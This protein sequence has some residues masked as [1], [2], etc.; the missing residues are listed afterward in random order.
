M[1]LGR[2][3]YWRQGRAKT[4]EEIWDAGPYYEQVSALLESAQEYVILAGWQIDS[5]LKLSSSPF[6]ESLKEKIRR[7]CQSKPRLHFYLLMWDHAYFL[8][9]ERELWQGRIWEGVHPNVHFVFDNRHPFGASHH[10]KVCITDGQTALCGGIDL[11]DERWDSPE[12][13]YLDPRRSLDGLSEHHG[14]YHDMAVRVTG[15]VCAYLQSHLGRRW[16]EL[17]SVP[18]PVP[19]PE[20]RAYSHEGHRVY[21]S[22]T[23]ATVDPAAPGRG[24]V[25][26]IEF[27]FRDLIAQARHRIVLEGQYFWSPQINDMLM[28]RMLDLRGS[29]FEVTLILAQI[30]GV[31]S[32]AREMAGHELRLLG[33]LREMAAF[34]ATK[35]KLG[36]P[37]VLSEDGSP[38]RP[39]YIHSKVAVI[40]DRFL[41]IGSANLATRALRL[42][43]EVNLTLEAETDDERRHIRAFGERLLAHWDRFAFREIRPELDLEYL[44]RLARWPGWHAITDPQLPWFYSFKRK[45]LR[46]H[47][48]AL[49]V[50]AVASVWAFGVLFAWALGRFLSRWPQA[51]PGQ[52]AFEAI[53]ASAWL[54]PIP[55]T[56]VSIAGFLLL[57]PEQALPSLLAGYESAFLFGYWAARIFPSTVARWFGMERRQLRLERLGQRSFASVVRWIIDPGLLLRSKIAGM[58]LCWIPFPWAA[59]A[60][61]LVLPA[62]TAWLAAGIARW[63]GAGWPG[64]PGFLR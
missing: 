43:T 14:P 61:G 42:D 51:K 27:L 22:R 57:P 23:L 48:P 34:T 55:A 54:A 62:A 47:R 4:W 41:S 13:R 8:V 6:P 15:S 32:L 46:R 36:T 28:A 29:G 53:L 40:D 31:R 1:S 2:R 26:E 38:P 44:P 3:A 35:L 30:R 39:V 58:G 12:H 18:F 10:E 11:C 33:R 60:F 50:L 52:L 20:A 17:S 59:L 24:I 25:R 37:F 7:L 49:A 5:R 45:L 9:P 64:F 16:R 19:P 21:L 56:G 63:A